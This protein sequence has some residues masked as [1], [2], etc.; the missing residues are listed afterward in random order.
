MTKTFQ[1]KDAN[2]VH[3]SAKGERVNLSEDLWGWDFKV[4]S[5]DSQNFNFT[6][7]TDNRFPPNASEFAL[8][9]MNHFNSVAMTAI[10]DGGY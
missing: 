10:T 9:L 8:A 4:T 2:R 6:M 3:W 1:W 7:H 5:D